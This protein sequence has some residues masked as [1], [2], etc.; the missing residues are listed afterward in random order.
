MVETM[1]LNF[2]R[3]SMKK[4]IIN[5]IFV[6]FFIFLIFFERF[7]LNGWRKLFFFFNWITC[8][9]DQRGGGAC[10][11][12]CLP[13]FMR[14]RNPSPTTPT[15]SLPPPFGPH[16]SLPRLPYW[17]PSPSLLRGWASSLIGSLASPHFYLTFHYK[18][19][20]LFTI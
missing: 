13:L 19:I 15:L 7:E 4:W 1:Y 12:G 17:I 14:S 10:M 2:F 6:D 20:N 8:R 5:S 3:G 18:K 11:D 9:H 16:L